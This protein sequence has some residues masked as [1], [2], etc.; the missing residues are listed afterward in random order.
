[1]AEYKPGSLLPGHAEAAVMDN[2]KVALCGMVLPVATPVPIYIGADCE[3]VDWTG[4]VVAPDVTVAALTA[5]A[6][7]LIEAKDAR[8]A[9]LETHIQELKDLL[10]NADVQVLIT[11]TDSTFA[12]R[13]EAE[14][15]ERAMPANALKHS[16]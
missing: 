2:G 8:I 16:R 3:T 5:D 7:A 11:R 15:V 4:G 1:M 9:E 13:A 6:R 12:D 10:Q 14:L